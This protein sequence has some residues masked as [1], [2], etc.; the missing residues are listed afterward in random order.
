[1]SVFTDASMPGI[2]ET[3][4]VG[5]LED[6]NTEE[7]GKHY[8]PLKAVCERVVSDVFG[9]R[10]IN[11]RPGLVVGPYDPTDRFSYWA[12]RFVHPHLLGPRTAA[13]VVPAPAERPL[14]FIDARDLA[15][16]MLALASDGAGGTF[17]ASSP[18]GLWTFGALVDALRAAGGPAA[19]RAAWIDE[20]TLEAHKVTP[21]T[22]LPLWIPTS[23]A[24]MAGF[25]RVDCSKAERAGL[26][27]RPLAAIVADTAAWLA[28]RD[29]SGA[30]KDALGADAEREILAEAEG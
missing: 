8:G 24:D 30:W 22:G 5:V 7:V 19:P 13:A 14:Q 15:A 21:W 17:N 16:W 3:S 1:V 10:A 2:D 12:A 6:P 27:M 29:N 23:F 20:A 18:A 25:Q 11:V 26:R 28:T 4:P 9:A